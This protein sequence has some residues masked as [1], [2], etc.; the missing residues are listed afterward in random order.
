MSRSILML[1]SIAL[2]AVPSVT[3]AAEAQSSAALH[4]HGGIHVETPAG[5]VSVGGGAAV[6]GGAGVS[7]EQAATGAE[8]GAT[9]QAQAQAQ[10]EAAPAEKKSRGILGWLFD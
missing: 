9:A 7:Q 3:L 1:A 4:G 8:A 5:G 6:E 2:A 10:A